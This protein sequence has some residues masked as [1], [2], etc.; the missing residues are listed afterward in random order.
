VQ[1]KSDVHFTFPAHEKFAGRR[2]KHNYSRKLKNGEKVDRCWLV[3]YMK[4]D[5]VFCYCCKLYSPAQHHWCKDGMGQQTPMKIKP[6]HLVSET[7]FSHF[8]SP[9]NFLFIYNILILMFT[10]ITGSVQTSFCI[11]GYSIYFLLL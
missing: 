4:A 7:F 9:Y 2:F 8:C 3:Y 11:C 5:A 10:K 1:I 6:T